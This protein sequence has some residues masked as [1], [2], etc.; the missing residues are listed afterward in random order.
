MGLAM[1]IILIGS[2]II[3]ETRSIILRKANDNVSEELHQDESNYFD[4][5][6]TL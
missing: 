5:F 3:N 4:D 1:F 2:L 6:E